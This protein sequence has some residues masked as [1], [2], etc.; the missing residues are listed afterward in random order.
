MVKVYTTNILNP[1]F[2]PPNRRG[3][4]MH[5]VS[6]IRTK[7]HIINGAAKCDWLGDT[8]SFIV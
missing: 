4:A 6:T 3:D 8:F 5:I 7:I 2:I 1:C